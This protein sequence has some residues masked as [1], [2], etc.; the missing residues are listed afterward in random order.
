MDENKEAHGLLEETKAS[1]AWI[2]LKA[3]GEESEHFDRF[4]Y[5]SNGEK[6]D[7]EFLEAV[8]SEG[9]PNGGWHHGNEHCVTMQS[10]GL[11]NDCKPYIYFPLTLHFFSMHNYRVL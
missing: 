7:T 2:G 4:R 3:L 5:V 1:S 10:W 9:E 11:W 6:P 8:F